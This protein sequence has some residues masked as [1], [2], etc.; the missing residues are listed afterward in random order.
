MAPKDDSPPIILRLQGRRIIPASEVDEELILAF[1]SGTEFK[2]RE[3][4][5]PR[6]KGLDAW[7]QLMGA[8][9]K[10]SDDWHSPRALSNALL[11]EMK[12]Y[13]SEKLIGGLRRTPM[14]LKDF[15]EDERFRLVM[16]AKMIIA[17]DITP[18]IDPDLL[19]EEM[20]RGSN[21]RNGYYE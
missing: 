12:L 15:T 2:V 18:E 8:V 9:A 4:K 1:R 16:V 14:S 19:I 17:R 20:K 5:T 7:W 3:T 6:S 10:Y 13:D 21:S 11:L